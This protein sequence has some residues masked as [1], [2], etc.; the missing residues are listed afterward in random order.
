M[1]T[2]LINVRSTKWKTTFDG[3]R[4]LVKDDLRWIQPLV[5]D[6]L[7]WKTAFGG[8]RPLVEEDLWGVYRSGSCIK[9]LCV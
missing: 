8:R 6:D 5:E 9:V 7:W 3:R 1:L 4:P 2:V